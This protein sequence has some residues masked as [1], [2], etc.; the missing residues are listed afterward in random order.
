[1]TT[2][3]ILQPPPS[4]QPADDE[5]LSVDNLS[6]TFAG[7]EGRAVH[8]VRGLSFGLRAN[9]VL[10]IVGESG[11]GKS[12]TS[13]SVM[14]LLP[15]DA[16]VTG[17]VRLAGRE[18]LGLDDREMS[19]LRGREL[20]MVFQEPLSALTP[21]YTVGQQV[22]E[23]LLIHQDISKDRAKARAVELLDLVGIPSPRE[24]ANAFPHEF[25]GGM[26]QR[27]VI[28]MAIANDPKVIIADEP[29]TALDVTI[30]D[31]K[32]VE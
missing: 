18:L 17:S 22:A 14:G 25:S 19:D 13:L 27:V 26:R 16:E 21:V 20:A 11:S 9:E 15:T 7:G 1:M 23:A 2:V 32:S 12:V 8:A 5:V 10:A 30:Q 3:D 31:R 28:A 29:T 6:V 24:R 4:R